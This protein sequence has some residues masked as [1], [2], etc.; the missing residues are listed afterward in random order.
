MTKAFI[1]VGQPSHDLK[2]FLFIFCWFCLFSLLLLT[3]HVLL[4]TLWA[5]R[6][7]WWDDFML[8]SSH[9]SVHNTLV[10]EVLCDIY[11]NSVTCI[12]ISS[13]PTSQSHML[14]CLHPREFIIVYNFELP[15]FIIYRFGLWVHTTPWWAP[16][17]VVSFEHEWHH[18]PK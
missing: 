5:W 4:F 9:C 6:H 15:H 8:A 3:I 18:N 7:A 2:L 14:S 13:L 10:R 16:C 12:S 17:G 1:K 11:T